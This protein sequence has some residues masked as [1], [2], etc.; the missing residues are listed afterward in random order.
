M[1]RAMVQIAGVVV[2]QLMAAAALLSYSTRGADQALHSAAST[3]QQCP[4]LASTC[5]C[6]ASPTS[7]PAPVSW[8]PAILNGLVAGSQLEHGQLDLDV[9]SACVLPAARLQSGHCTKRSCKRVSWAPQN[10]QELT[11]CTGAA[12]DAGGTSSTSGISS[13]T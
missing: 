13:N 2:A 11:G 12:I 1:D 3:V 4:S 9:A 10:A 8:R 5:A 7:S 6:A